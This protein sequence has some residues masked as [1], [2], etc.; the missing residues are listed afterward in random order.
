MKRRAGTLLLA[1]VLA[2][3]PIACASLEQ[4][5]E[6]AATLSEAAQPTPT[7]IATQ[8]LTPMP[9]ATEPPVPPLA[10]TATPMPTRTASP[11]PTVAAD[12]DEEEIAEEQLLAVMMTELLLVMLEETATQVQLG[13]IDG[14]EAWGQLLAILAISN[15]VDEALEAAPPPALEAAWLEA[16]EAVSLIGSVAFAWFDGEIGSDQV[17]EALGPARQAVNRSMELAGAVLSREYGVD[18]AEWD[19]TRE[20]IMDEL[21]RELRGEETDE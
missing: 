3:L 4:P 12:R 8:A 11:A 5:V 9:T 19:A 17:L 20:Q 10:V 6:P 16:R 15:V 7:E 13:E 18:P 14:L 21:R 1:M 2:I